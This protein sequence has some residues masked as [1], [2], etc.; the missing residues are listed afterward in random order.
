MIINVF[1]YREPCVQACGW[2]GFPSGFEFVPYGEHGT[3]R[4][5]R[6]R[7]SGAGCG[8]VCRRGKCH[9]NDLQIICIECSDRN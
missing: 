4:V 1:V 2:N 9:R 3:A 8:G 6:T 7:Q 5:C